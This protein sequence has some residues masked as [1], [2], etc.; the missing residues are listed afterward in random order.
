VCVF[1]S[2][3]VCLC[4]CVCARLCVCVC[5]YVCVCVCVFVFACR[6]AACVGEALHVFVRVCVRVLLFGRWLITWAAVPK[7]CWLNVKVGLF[8]SCCP[9]AVFCRCVLLFCDIWLAACVGE[10]RR[11]ETKTCAAGGGGTQVAQA[12]NKEVRFS[13]RGAVCLEQIRARQTWGK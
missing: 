4:V 9:F 6:F 1:V 8:R 12:R 11:V 7:T 3:C 5:L 2:L 10:A 13:T